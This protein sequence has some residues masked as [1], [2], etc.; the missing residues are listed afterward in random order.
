VA[1]AVNMGGLG[2]GPLFAGLLA[3]FAP[4]PTTLPFE[5]YLVPLV[6]GAAAVAVV[7]ETVKSAGTAG[8]QFARLRLPP[9]GRTEFLAASVSAFIAFSLLGLFSAL[10]PSFLGNVLHEHSHAIAGAVVALIFGAATATQLALAFRPDRLSM[11]AGLVLILP[12]LAIIVLALAEA[13][14]PVF[15]AG[16][17]IGGMAVGA[18]FVGSLHT[19]SRLA[20]ADSRAE[21]ISLYFTFAYVGLTIPVLAV[22]FAAE[23]VGDLPAVA[24]CASVLAVVAV[25]ALA[26]G[27]WT[28]RT[29]RG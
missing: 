1:T 12:G 23:H 29:A 27:A 24:V 20:P 4:H 3:E 21:V 10:A 2:L 7:P 28:T 13:S 26:A 6:I 19:A 25:T 22:G 5:L 16:T 15:L 18:C 17:V 8:R 14:L 11:R 9:S